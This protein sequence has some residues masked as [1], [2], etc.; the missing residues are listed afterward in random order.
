MNSIINCNNCNQE[1]IPKYKIGKNKY[2]C[3]NCAEKHYNEL[4]NKLNKR[5]ENLQYTL[6]HEKNK[7]Q[8]FIYA[9]CDH[10]DYVKTGYCIGSGDT[11][12]EV[13][14]CKK[15]SKTIYKNYY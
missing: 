13:C 1:T 12:K 8:N 6:R 2:L 10:S 4:S 3:V 14:V 5:I 9:S 7:L 11:L 15:C